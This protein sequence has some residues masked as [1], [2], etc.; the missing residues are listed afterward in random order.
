MI[1][2]TAKGDSKITIQGTS[3]EL[4][5]VVLRLQ[6]FLPT[7]GESLE[8]ACDAY[9]SKEAYKAGAAPV[10]IE[11]FQTSSKIYSLVKADGSNKDQSRTVA[12]TEMKAYLVG[13]GYT[14]MVTM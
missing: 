6:A 12:H 13:L 9:E 11:G 3:I 1:K 2:V 5:S 10:I 14:A 7:K 8:V 4:P